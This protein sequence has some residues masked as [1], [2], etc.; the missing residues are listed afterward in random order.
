[1]NSLLNLM[2][3]LRLVNLFI[4]FSLIKKKENLNDKS[5]IGNKI[6]CSLK[7]MGKFKKEFKL[8]LLRLV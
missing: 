2:N 1:V 5:F 4:T 6:E 7:F 3:Q 8:N